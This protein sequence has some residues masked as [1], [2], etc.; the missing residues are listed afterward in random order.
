[1]QVLFEDIQ[2]RLGARCVELPV[3]EG[4]TRAGVGVVD[5]EPISSAGMH[6]AA[7]NNN[8][9]AAKLRNLDINNPLAGNTSTTT[10]TDDPAADHD[11]AGKKPEAA[12]GVR[13]LMVAGTVS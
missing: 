6:I 11:S 7:D 9:I 5:S 4:V 1:M 3:P 13:P 10:T 8:D 12:V 2:G